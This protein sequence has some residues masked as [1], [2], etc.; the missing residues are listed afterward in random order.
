MPS[1]SAVIRGFVQRA[2]PSPNVDSSNN[3]VAVRL[4]T[5]ASVFTQPLVRKSHNLADEGSYFVTNNAQT[6]IASA[7]NTSFTA[8]APFVLIYN[9]NLSTA[10]A[11]LRV[12]IDYIALVAIAAGASTTT[13]GYVAAAI[14]VDT[15]NRYTSGGTNL[16]ANIV[17]PNYA[18]AGP[19]SGI[20]IYC[21]AITA[22]SASG[23]VRTVVGVRNIRPSVSSTVI[24]VVGDMNLI[25]FG[26]V[27]GS[28]GSITVANANIMP[29]AFPPIIIPPG[30]S[31]LFYLTYP[32]M[33]APSAATFAPEIGF[34]VR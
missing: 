3:D 20:S 5:Y 10:G 12:Y 17:S 13:A 4:D 11:G 14:T 22:T 33:S 25:T 19:P 23:S 2:L 31:G 24:N 32:V 34:W 8:T 9:G 7:Y 28:T 15:G 18:V 6:G 16:T 29:Q 26:S 1:P 21:G 27:E 30:A